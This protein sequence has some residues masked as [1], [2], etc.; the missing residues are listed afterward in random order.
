MDVPSKDEAVAPT[1][2]ALKKKLV[3]Q[4]MLAGLNPQRH[5]AQ[6]SAFAAHHANFFQF[7]Q[8]S[9]ALV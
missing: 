2:H 7:Q 5:F 9:H 4:A 8:R 1:N 6:S 3:Q